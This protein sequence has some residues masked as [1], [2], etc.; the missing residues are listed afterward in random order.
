MLFQP[1]AQCVPNILLKFK[2]KFPTCFSKFP[3][4]FQILSFFDPYFC[5]KLNFH[6]T[7]IKVG[8]IDVRVFIFLVWG[9]T[10]VSK[11]IYNGPIIW[12]LIRGEFVFW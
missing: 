10:N 7:Y 11:E 4:M 1:H 3:N 6:L 2:M 8:Q 9:M 12:L 5:S